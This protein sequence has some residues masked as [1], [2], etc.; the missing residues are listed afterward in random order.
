MHGQGAGDPAAVALLAARRGSADHEGLL[1]AADSDLERALGLV[2]PELLAAASF[3]LA[4][5]AVR[6][7]GVF[8]GG[9]NWLDIRTGGELKAWIDET[10]APFN[11]PA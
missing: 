3:D 4:W 10:K 2:E 7:V 1:L 9:T 8:R 11:K 6:N 5:P